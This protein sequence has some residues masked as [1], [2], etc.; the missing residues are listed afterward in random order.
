[1]TRQVMGGDL[2]AAI[3]DVRLRIPFPGVLGRVCTAKCEIGCRRRDVDG[4]VSIRSL[5]RHVADE[6]RENGD[7]WLPPCAEDTGRRVAVVGAGPAGL[8]AAYFLRLA[9][10][11]VTV[12][13]RHGE[14]GGLLRREFDEEVLP[15]DVLEDELSIVTRLGAE[16]RCGVNVG[17][18]PSLDALLAEHDAVLLA[19]AGVSDAGAGPPLF[20]AGDA[21]R[22]IDDPLRAMVSGR[23][24]A[25]AIDAHL[26]GRPFE[27]PTREF[28]TTV[29]KLRE[30][31]LAQY[32]EGAEEEASARPDGDDAAAESARCLRCDCRATETCLLKHYAEE[33]GASHTRFRVKRRV[34]ERKADHPHVVYEPGKCIACGI[35]VTITEETGEELGL[36]FVGRGFDVRVDV[37]FD[38]P[39]STAL[40]RAAAEV[41][42]QC[43]TGALAFH[44]RTKK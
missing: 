7:P 28:S 30:P 18:D 22:R 15:R 5:E 12:F 42:K 33:L 9:G 44:D 39:L 3:A 32:V 13:E 1:M 37:P 29:G 16:V 25:A 23:D 38:A 4:A 14:T 31:E 8:S 40:R 6:D 43:P 26:S 11:A 2:V 34:F 35:C 20:A 21:V 17:S 24:A 19:A 36:T 41:V 10:H 27:G